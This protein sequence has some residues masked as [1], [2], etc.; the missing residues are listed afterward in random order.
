MPGPLDRGSPCSR[1]G[2][3]RLPETVWPH[4]MEEMS[5]VPGQSEQY[6]VPPTENT[7]ELKSSTFSMGYIFN[8]ELVSR[9][10]YKYIEPHESL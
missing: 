7:A 5:T 3:P 4:E 8:K 6:M 10:I 1:S 9:S 2:L